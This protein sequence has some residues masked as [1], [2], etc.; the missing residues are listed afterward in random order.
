[1]EKQRIHPLEK[2][3][4]DTQAFL[5]V[6]NG[7]PDFSVV[8]IS[9]GYV[10]ACLAAL[11]HRFLIQSSVTEEL[12]D[13]RRGPLGSFATKADLAYVLGLIPKS[14]YLDLQQLAEI[15]NQVAHHHLNL[16]FADASISDACLKLQYLGTLKIGDFD[17]P[18]FPP[19]RMPSPKEQFKFTAVVI[20]NLLLT[21]S[22]R[23]A[24]RETAA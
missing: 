11:L 18:A 12:L 23:I 2:L 21:E 7:E 20:S 22:E 17:E 1:M 9:I 4:A 5:D 8:I 19:E 16:N 10:D 6:L 24:R 3:R 14:M 13:P 15:R